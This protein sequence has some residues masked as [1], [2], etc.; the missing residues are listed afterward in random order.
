VGAALDRKSYPEIDDQERRTLLT[1]AK[2]AMEEDGESDEDL[3]D[4]DGEGE[5]HRALSARELKK[6]RKEAKTQCEEILK[7]FNADFAIVNEGGK[8]WIFAER[9]D[10]MLD[11]HFYERMRPESFM[12][13]FG[14]RKVCTRVDD[15]GKAH[16]QSVARWWLQHPERREYTVGWR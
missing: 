7:K 5:G 1:I 9:Y 4:F 14:P 8:A 15:T 16:F 2:K 13:L 3:D 6:K 10:E 12:L 11:R